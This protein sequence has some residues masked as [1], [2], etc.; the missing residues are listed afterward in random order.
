L[1]A[2]VTVAADDKQGRLRLLRYGARPALSSRNLSLLPDGRVRYELRHTAGPG[3]PQALI[4]QPTELLHRLAAILPRP[5]QHRTVYH[6]IFSPAAN[7]RFEVSPAAA[8]AARAARA[9]HPGAR[10]PSHTL[11]SPPAACR[12]GLEP[13]HPRPVADPAATEAAADHNAEA[14]AMARF[15]APPHRLPSGRFPW[16]EL[17]RRTFPGALSCPKRGAA[18]SV[19]AFITELAVVRKIL[20]HLGLPAGAPLLAPARLPQE[21]SLDFDL[22]DLPTRT[23][24]EGDLE[25]AVPRQSRAPPQDDPCL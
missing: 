14:Q 17:I 2:A 7:R 13:S 10:A 11:Q 16:A 1:H 25:R 18:L 22:Q 8:R 9:T 15:C 21:L 3:S 5:Y 6:G 23:S 12:Y 4:L 19:I 24:A 20:E